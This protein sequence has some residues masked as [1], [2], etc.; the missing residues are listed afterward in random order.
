MV[1]SLV[2]QLLLEL[3]LV[4]AHHFRVPCLKAIGGTQL[5][6]FAISIEQWVIVGIDYFVVDGIFDRLAVSLIYPEL[7]FMCYFIHIDVVGNYSQ[8][9][10]LFNH[11]I[12]CQF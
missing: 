5:S 12:N 4:R 10:H 9:Y 7:H 1:C 11:P 6:L 2:L 3:I 8:I